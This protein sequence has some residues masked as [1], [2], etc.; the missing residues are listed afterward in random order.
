MGVHDGPDN[1]GP[2]L[3]QDVAHFPPGGSRKLLIRL[4]I[5]YVNSSSQYNFLDNTYVHTNNYHHHHPR[6]MLARTPGDIGL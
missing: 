4:L 5:A 1:N 2:H 6:I 3:P